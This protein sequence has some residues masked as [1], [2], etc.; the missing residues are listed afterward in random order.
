M[1][2]AEVQQ[3]NLKIYEELSKGRH[4]YRVAEK[5]GL[6][7]LRVRQIKREIELK[8]ENGKWINYIVYPKI[9]MWFNRNVNGLEKM[10]ESG[11]NV[12][13]VISFLCDD[14]RTLSV[15]TINTMLDVMD[16]S[17]EEAFERRNK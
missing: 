11:L 17:F 4:V 13:S 1:T 6:T 15:K 7:E 2:R 3:R 14:A 5:Y 10:K 8:E 9:K 12:E 16:I